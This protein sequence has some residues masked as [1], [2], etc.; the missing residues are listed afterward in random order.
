MIVGRPQFHVAIYA[1]ANGHR[2]EVQC[3]LGFPLRQRRN[4]SVEKI[5]EIHSTQ[6]GS[7]WGFEPGYDIYNHKIRRPGC[8]AGADYKHVIL[9]T[10]RLRRWR[11]KIFG[12]F[13]FDAGRM[14][15]PQEQCRLADGR[16]PTSI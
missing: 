7:T 1:S 10:E 5:P 14:L 8:S 9:S 13:S 12:G 3:R 11:K 4:L 2:F 6:R 16:W 15:Q